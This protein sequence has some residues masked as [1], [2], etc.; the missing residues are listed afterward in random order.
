MPAGISWSVQDAPTAI[1][2][3]RTDVHM[4]VSVL[5]CF[6]LRVYTKVNRWLEIGD[7]RHLPQGGS[8][9]MERFH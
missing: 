9:Q 8:G 7:R 3:N 5:Y 1:V 2:G 4:F 6:I